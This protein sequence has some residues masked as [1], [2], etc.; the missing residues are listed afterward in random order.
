LP[1]IERDVNRTLPN[2]FSIN[3]RHFADLGKFFARIDQPAA[4]FIAIDVLVLVVN[5][6]PVGRIIECLREN[7]APQRSFGIA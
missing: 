2:D 6:Q 1:A 5:R 3:S 7:G 4:R